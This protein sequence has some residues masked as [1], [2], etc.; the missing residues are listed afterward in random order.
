MRETLE[1]ALLALVQAGPSVAESIE[2]QVEEQAAE[3]ETEE[4]DTDPTPT[5]E[6]PAIDATIEALTRSASEHFEAAEAAQRAG[7]WAVY[8]RELDAL[9]QD[10]EQ[11]LE[12]TNM[13]GN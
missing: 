8:G 9:R 2:A 13:E 6:T 10:L 3:Q 5:P 12:L 11:L 7:D 1:E 4:A